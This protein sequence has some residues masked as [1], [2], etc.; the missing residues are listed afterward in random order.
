ML[1]IFIAA[2]AKTLDND[3]DDG[4]MNGWVEKTSYKKNQSWI[5]MDKQLHG[6]ALCFFLGGIK[7]GVSRWYHV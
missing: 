4:W 1:M 3:D 7:S 2:H 6:L 5:S